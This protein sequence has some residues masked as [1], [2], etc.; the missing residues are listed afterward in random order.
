MFENL[1]EPK[2]QYLLIQIESKRMGEKLNVL[3]LKL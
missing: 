3:H 1:Q 2:M